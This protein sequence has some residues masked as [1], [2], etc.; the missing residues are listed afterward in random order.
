MPLTSTIIPRRK[1][2]GL[3]RMIQERAWVRH[4][5]SVTRQR[6]SGGILVLLAISFGLYLYTTRDEAIRLRVINFLADATGGKPTDFGDVQVGSAH[7]RMFGGITLNNV[8]VS[9]PYD[10][11]LDPL[12]KDA[13]SRR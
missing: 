10:D 13:R 5:V 8:Q 11:K 6:L 12:A 4:P 2:P 1:T 9:V 3:R 7:F